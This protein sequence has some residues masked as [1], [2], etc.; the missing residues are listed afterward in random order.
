MSGGKEKARPD[1]DHRLWFDGL[2][3]PLP[4]AHP[5]PRQ[6]SEQIAQVILIAGPSGSGKSYIAR[7]TGLP[8]LCLDDFYKSGE[9]PTLPRISGTIDWESPESWDAK[10][11]LA[12]IEQLACTGRVEVPAY[13]FSANR[14]IGLHTVST[15]GRPLFIAE[16]IFAA[17][18]AAECLERG[19]LAGAFAVRRPRLVT[20]VRRLARDLAEHR[21]PP[22]VLVRRGLRLLRADPRVLARQ[23]ELGCRPA[24]ARGI[25]RAASRRPV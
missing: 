3:V 16:G 25:R 4:Y 5:E 20:F 19:L 10:A 18:I 12:A 9:D 23:A 14:P 22:V 8:I 11:A 21:K 17:E 7:R 1:P 6:V 24:S 2:T 15:G 13:S